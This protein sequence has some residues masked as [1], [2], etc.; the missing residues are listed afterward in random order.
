MGPLARKS[1]TVSRLL[2]LYYLATPLFAALDVITG[3][4]VRTAAF[5]DSPLRWLYYAGSFGCG[6]VAVW[7]PAVA[8]LVAMI[9][10]AANILLLMLSILLPIWSFLDNAETAVAAPRLLTGPALANVVISG[11]V[12]VVSFYGSQ[13]RLFVG[14]S[15]G[16]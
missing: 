13:A 8:P 2:S 6:L 7:R 3:V 15:T 16:P 4:N 10:S 9:E 11:G 5:G 14:K 12:L 1:V